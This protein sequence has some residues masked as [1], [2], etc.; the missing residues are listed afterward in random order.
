MISKM[1]TAG[2]LRFIGV[3]MFSLDFGHFFNLLPILL[4][5]MMFCSL[6]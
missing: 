5:S 2:L 6:K 3:L 4:F 1:A